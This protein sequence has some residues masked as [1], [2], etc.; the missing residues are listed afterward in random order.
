MPEFGVATLWKTTTQAFAA[1]A[2]VEVP[3]EV[4]E[5][6]DISNVC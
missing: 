1:S 6:N 3:I 4:A 2:T 5:A